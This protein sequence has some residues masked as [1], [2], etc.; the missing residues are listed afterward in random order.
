MP[1]VPMHLDLLR[2]DLGLGQQ[3]ARRAPI[4]LAARQEQRVD[5]RVLRRLPRWIAA[6]ILRMGSSIA[7]AEPEIGLK[8]DNRAA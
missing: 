4:L 3:A 1:P 7:L 2:V 5:R 8:R 6:L